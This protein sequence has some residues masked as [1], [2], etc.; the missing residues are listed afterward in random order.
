MLIDCPRC[1]A[2]VDAKILAEHVTSPPDDIPYKY[3]LLRCPSCK[4]IILAS[5]WSDLDPNSDTG[6]DT[7][8]RLWPVPDKFSFGSIP[9]MVRKALEDAHRCYSA[10]VYSACAVMC[11]KAIE[12][13]CVEKSGKKNL[14]E[15]L[16]ELKK[17]KVIDDRLFSWGEVLRKERNLGAHANEES[18]TAQD[19]KDVLDFAI[20]ICEYV[21]VLSEKY[22][23]FVDRKAKK[24]KKKAATA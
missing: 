10:E 22:E 13:I 6:W 23:E 12:A 24:A 4:D 2:R 8:S 11:G 5:A 9:S 15:G 17:L 14:S 16:R 19:A 3:I 21:Y 1:I 20:A 18:T 7:P